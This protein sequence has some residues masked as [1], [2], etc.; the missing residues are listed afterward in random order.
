MNTPSIGQVIQLIL[1]PML[2]L[3]ASA[4]LIGGAPR[5][6]TLR[7]GDR[8]PTGTA[9]LSAEKYARRRV[10]NGIPRDTITRGD[11]MMD[12]SKGEWA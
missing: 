11:L 10:P 2:M 5:V 4:I 1:A 6:L 8:H 3:T 7:L 9:G 12:P